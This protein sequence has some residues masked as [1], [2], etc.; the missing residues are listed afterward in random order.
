M[1]SFI[2]KNSNLLK[3]RAS[4]VPVRVSALSTVQES[5]LK[6]PFLVYL[7]ISAR[8]RYTD[9]AGRSRAAIAFGKTRFSKI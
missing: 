5:F 3:G 8:L 2:L 9:D 7:G 1:N 4:F 6:H